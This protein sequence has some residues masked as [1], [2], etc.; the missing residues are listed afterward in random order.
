MVADER[1]T[2]MATS[3]RCIV[4]ETRILR[5]A[6]VSPLDKGL[7]LFINISNNILTRRI[8]I[9]II[10]LFDPHY[11]PPSVLACSYMLRSEHLKGKE[12]LIIY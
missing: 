10:T 7:S 2:F 9:P 3:M 1:E 5:K 6:R 8:F 12:G 4:H 11:P